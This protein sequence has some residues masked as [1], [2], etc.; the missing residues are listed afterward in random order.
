V[1]SIPIAGGECEFTRFGFRDLFLSRAL[2]IAQP[3]ICAAGGFSECE[4]IADMAEAFGVR[5]IPHVCGIKPYHSSFSMASVRDSTGRSVI[6]KSGKLIKILWHDG[7]G[8]SLYAK[9]LERGRFL[10]RRRLM[11]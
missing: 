1:L 10:G 6:S 8:M 7:L 3:D 5:Y 4:K 11:A 2:D 9:R